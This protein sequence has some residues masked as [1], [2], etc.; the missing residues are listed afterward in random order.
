M[1]NNW[2]SLLKPGVVEKEDVSANCARFTAMPLE[3][4]FGL[5]LGNALRRVL[6]GSL[7]GAADVGL[8][9]DGVEHE[10]KSLPDVSAKRETSSI[11]EIAV[12]VEA[13]PVPV[14]AAVQLSTAPEASTP[15]GYWPA[16]QLAPLAAR[17]V[18][19]AASVALATALEI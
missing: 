12:S 11:T 18:A 7:Q 9:I 1:Q 8:K 3:R 17:A 16:V 6:I 4:G 5:T 2:K 10:F 19:L 13:S 15:K 14:A